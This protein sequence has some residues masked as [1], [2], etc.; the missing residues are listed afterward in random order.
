MT[1]SME[2]MFGGA[3]HDQVLFCQDRSTGLKAFIALHDLSLGL[4][5]GGTRLRPY[6]SLRSALDDALRLSRHMSLKA[7]CAGLPIGGAKGVIVGDP[8]RK[9]PELLA[10]YASFVDR[11]G[12]LFVTGQDMNLSRADVEYLSSRTPFIAGVREDCPDPSRMTAL[13]V[14]SGI[15]AALAFVYGDSSLRG[16]TVAVQGVGATGQE[17][18]RLLALAG[19]GLVVCDLNPERAAAMRELYDARVVEPG[20]ILQCAADVLAPCASGGVIDE[21][22]AGRLQFAIVAG[23]ANNQLVQE[24]RDAA[25]LRDRGIL[26]CPDFVINGGGLIEVFHQ[27]GRYDERVVATQV[28]GIG[29]TLRRIFVAA[30]AESQSTLHVVKSMSWDAAEAP[31]RKY[32]ASEEAPYAGSRRRAVVQY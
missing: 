17:L 20:E 12:G 30:E 14:F 24:D 28:E 3:D 21:E 19:A 26:Y 8:A 7:K 11:L 1:L 18:C 27:G 9:S 23:S 32:G 29:E 31:R 22:V 2:A 13:G 6:A 15:R 25:L 10:S 5:M 4:A 16:R